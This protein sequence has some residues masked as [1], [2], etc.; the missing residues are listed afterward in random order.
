MQDV[1]D[2]EITQSLAP[3]IPT[4]LE[5]RQADLGKLA[6]TLD[7]NDVRALLNIAHKLK[8]NGAS[9]GFNRITELGELLERA[10]M[11]GERARDVCSELAIFLT[12]LKVV[13]R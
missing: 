9:Y 2:V 3:L 7:T 6:V 12:N 10:A 11:A 4:Y 13:Y 1:E 5:N 8:G